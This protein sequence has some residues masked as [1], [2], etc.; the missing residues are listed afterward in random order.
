MLKDDGSW[1]EIGI[2][3]SNYIISMAASSVMFLLLRMATVLMRCSFK[4][5]INEWKYFIFKMHNK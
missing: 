5:R 2:S 4:E 1:L 3:I